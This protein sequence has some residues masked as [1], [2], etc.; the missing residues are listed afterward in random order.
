MIISINM[1]TKIYLIYAKRGVHQFAEH[2]YILDM[3][4]CTDIDAKN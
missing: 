2:G 1:A 4:V 3:I